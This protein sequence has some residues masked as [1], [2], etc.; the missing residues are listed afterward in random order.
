M[1]WVG[2]CGRG[3]AA[4]AQRA[5]EAARQPT[6]LSLEPEDVQRLAREREWK[7]LV[8][9]VAAVF[10]SPALLEALDALHGG[11]RRWGGRPAGSAI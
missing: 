7:G 11:R 8:S 1:G 10:S 9:L 5:A 3:Q 4:G 6:T 2:F